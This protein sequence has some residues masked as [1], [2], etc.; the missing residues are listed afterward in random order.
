MNIVGKILVILNLLFALVVGGFLI[1]DVARRTNWKNE[2]ENRDRDLRSAYISIKTHEETSLR[3]HNE[4]KTARDQLKRTAQTGIATDNKLSDEIKAYEIRLVNMK[5]DIEEAKLVAAKALKESERY[6]EE[7]ALL[8]KTVT[9]R[10]TDILALNEKYQEKQKEHMAEKE[11]AD[12]LQARA[13]SLME[14]L[15]YARRKLAEFEARGGSATGVVPASGNAKNLYQA[16]PPPKKV[17]GKIERID[18]Q[19]RSLVEVNVGLDDGVDKNHTLEVYR[20]SPNPEYLGMILILDSEAH[21][22]RG[23][24]IRNPYGP[25]PKALKQGDEVSGSL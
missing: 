15:R 14:D 12:A 10:D 4:L 5:Q 16:N 2:I 23:R 17:K 18:S 21:K 13:A 24:L 11:R 6:I 22:A 1:I 20:K 19:D 25:P 9:N 3:L 8:K 7:I